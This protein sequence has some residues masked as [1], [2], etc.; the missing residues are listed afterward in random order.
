MSR[1]IKLKIYIYTWSYEYGYYGASIWHISRISMGR[2]HPK[3][4]HIHA[5]KTLPW[6]QS[7]IKLLFT[8][9]LLDFSLFRYINIL[10]VC[11]KLN[12]R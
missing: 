10:F 2:F 6:L 11:I 5:H 4:T 12:S 1:I 9:F 8:R 3:N 7:Q